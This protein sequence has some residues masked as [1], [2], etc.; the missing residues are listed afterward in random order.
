MGGSPVQPYQYLTDDGLKFMAIEVKGIVLHGHAALVNH[1]LQ[2]VGDYPMWLLVRHEPEA[3]VVSYVVVAFEGEYIRIAPELH[4][5]GEVSLVFA[6]Y[7]QFEPP[8]PATN[9]AILFPRNPYP[10]TPE[11]RNVILDGDIK[12]ASLRTSHAR[13]IPKLIHANDVEGV[14]KVARYL[15]PAARVEV[16]LALPA[17]D[18]NSVMVGSY[19]LNHVL[20]KELRDIEH[21]YQSKNNH[22]DAA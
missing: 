7:P 11:I 10:I 18:Q 2:T 1:Y 22:R 5:D 14:A 6:E 13:Q 16:N 9:E 12:M 20:Q 17:S 19:T 8:G 3:A 15:Y 21:Q 4:E